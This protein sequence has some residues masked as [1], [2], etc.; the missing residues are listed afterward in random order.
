MQEILNVLLRK[1]EYEEVSNEDNLRK[2]LR[3]KAAKWACSLDDRKCK[4]TAS[5]NLRRHLANP[6]KNK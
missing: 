5:H 4:E 6:E 3:Q 2:C 1:L